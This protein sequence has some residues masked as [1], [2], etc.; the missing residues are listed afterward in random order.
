MLNRGPDP[1]RAAGA[2]DR[3]EEP[4]QEDA[5][6]GD[7]GVS[8]LW[9]ARAGVGGFEIDDQANDDRSNVRPP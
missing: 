1:L 6:D 2:L 7:F 8:R 9:E 4:R 3:Q 5:R